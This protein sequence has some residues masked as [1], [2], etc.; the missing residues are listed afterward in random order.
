MWI[1]VEG[2]ATAA[3][4]ARGHGRAAPR[5]CARSA[6][7]MQARIDFSS[8]TPAALRPPPPNSEIKQ[9]ANDFGLTGRTHTVKVDRVG[10]QQPQPIQLVG[11]SAQVGMALKVYGVVLAP[12]DI[13]RFS[14]H[15][16]SSDAWLTVF[17][18]NRAA[19]VFEAV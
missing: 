16:H 15:A 18:K 9:A 3:P 10:P 7:G 13:L 11:R 4:H 12:L 14:G 17:S 1:S 6:L 19:E 8:S 5:R 2:E